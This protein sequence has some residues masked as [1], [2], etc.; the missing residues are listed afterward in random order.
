M[1]CQ[2][3]VDLGQDLTFTITT[4]DP[5]TGILTDADF[6]P[7]YRVYEDETAVPLLIGTMTLLDAGGTT[8]FY[9]E[10]IA[11]TAGNGFEHNR[12]YNV[13]IEATV[14]GDM[15]GISYGFRSYVPLSA[16]DVVSL[17]LSHTII[18]GALR[19]MDLYLYRGD[20]WSQVITG[21]GDLTAATD[22]W[23]AMKEDPDD[24][25]N[26]AIALISETVGLERINGAVAAVPGN[27]SITVIAP[28]T[29]GVIRVDL[30]EVETAKLVPDRRFW[31]AQK[32]VTGTVTTP[33][34]GRISIQ[35]DI[36]R[37]VT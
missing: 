20:T 19:P 29:R 9:S 26:Q 23:F 6:P 37:A 25:D 21:L 30:D 4:H 28:A 35:A 18:A 11:C 17:L 24:T 7:I 27:G 34:A 10:L 2:T 36:V 13:Y 3:E 33:K 32:L 22:I 1:G 8:G 31:D 5:D 16:S 15:G 12:S 14:D